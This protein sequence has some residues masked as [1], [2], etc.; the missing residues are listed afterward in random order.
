M[1]NNQ[2][3]YQFREKVLTKTANIF[4][5]LI[6]VSMII[7][8]FMVSIKPL[9]FIVAGVIATSLFLFPFY[10]KKYFR[11]RFGSTYMLTAL[12]ILSFLA[13]YTNGGVQAP[14]VMILI[15]CPLLGVVTGGF[16]GAVLG[17]SLAFTA[18]VSLVLL[19]I[20]DAVLPLRHP[21]IFHLY[22]PVILCAVAISALVIGVVYENYRR[23]SQKRIM[24][25]S[26]KAQQSSR[27]AAIGEMAAGM[28][29]EINNPLSIISLNAELV[30]HLI[31]QPDFNQEHILQK[32]QTISSTTFRAAKIIEGLRTFSKSAETDPYQKIELQSLIT[33]V[34]EMCQSR[35]KSHGIEIRLPEIP[36]IE[37]EC[38]STHISQVL[39]NLLNNAFDAIQYQS[40]KWVSI[41]VKMLEKN[42]IN[43]YVTDSGTGIPREL[44]NK[45]VQP[46][47]TTKPVGKGTG[48]GLSISKGII[49]A[50]QGHMWVDES[51]PNT[52]FA[53]Q[54]PVLHS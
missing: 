32:L 13:G 12:T 9:P 29:H 41:E 23:E 43:I 10:P 31:K 4:G 19:Q 44:V 45:I 28:A 11:L 21:E 51:H 49:E 25:I 3:D 54:I 7:R 18:I 14:G 53:F 40:E 39:L 15:L 8:Y 46:F 37:I 48:L 34:F 50:H 42:F 2:F 33:G 27:M 6:I 35:F 17:C 36:S 5:L 47:F 22:M 26:I 1:D 38:R 20:N 16:K 30:S 24:E 52:R